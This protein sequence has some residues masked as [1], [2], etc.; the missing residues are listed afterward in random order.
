MKKLI[1]LCCLFAII[2]CSLI[3]VAEETRHDAGEAVKAYPRKC[4]FD[5]LP[6]SVQLH[7]GVISGSLPADDQA[8]EELA[9]LGIKTIISVDGA[10]P[11][12]KAAK[13]HGL[14]YVHLP[15]G[16]DGVPDQRVMELAKAFRDLGGPIY[17]HCHHG[18]HRSPAA[19]SAACVAG[20]MIPPSDARTVLEMAGT[21]PN[22]RGLY[23]SADRAKR[24]PDET[25][26]QL[27]VEF[28]EVEQVPAVAQA[29]VNIEHT[30]HY[31][32]LIAAAQWKSPQQHPDLDPAH[33]ALILREHF[34]ELLRSEET[35]NWP[36]P[37]L[38]LLRDSE[39]DAQKLETELRNGMRPGNLNQISQ[40]ISA[41]CKSCHQQFRDTP[42]SEK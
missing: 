28:Q 40:R 25:L 24:V 35:Q 26:D 11:D 16:Y 30:H 1:S 38:Q 33:E 8:F 14:R 34:T 10:R 6:N 9:N 20:G 21:D 13:R 37:I 29:M 42:L 41:N 2:C 5:H 4:S 18:K 39:T 36:K 3:G 31:L 32:K 23:Q 19:A 27:A 22:Y 7:A 15:H 17:I 12:V